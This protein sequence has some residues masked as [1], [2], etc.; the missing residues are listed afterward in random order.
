MKAKAIDLESQVEFELAKF[1]GVLQ[2]RRVEGTVCILRKTPGHPREP[3]LATVALPVKRT[4]QRR[5]NS[6]T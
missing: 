5:S 3:L 4:N 2:S 1:R 6:W